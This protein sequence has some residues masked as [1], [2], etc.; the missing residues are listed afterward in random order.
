MCSRSSRDQRDALSSP[1]RLEFAYSPRIG[2]EGDADNEL[3]DRTDG[4]LPSGTTTVGV[5]PL[6]CDQGPIPTHQRIRRHQRVEFA[7]C[8]ASSR[9][10]S[11]RQSTPLG[12][13]KSNA[14]AAQTFLQ[15]SILF[16]QILDRLE[17]PTMNPSG[18]QG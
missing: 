11:A 2:F 6:P 18:K 12:I 13:S 10:R 17:L 16:F 3:D 9:M 15:Q 5:G 8:L 4:A 1:V 14:S 7:E